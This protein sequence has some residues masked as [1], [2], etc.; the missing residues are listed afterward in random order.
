MAETKS[1][2]QLRTQSN[3][4]VLPSVRSYRIWT[5]GRLR[6]AERQADSGLIRDAVDICDW[7]LGDDRVRGALDARLDA[8]F[9]LTPTFETGTGRKKR[10]ALKAL[11]ADEDFWAIFPEE[12]ARQIQYWAILLG[13]GPGIARWNPDEDHGD[14]DLPVVKFYHPQPLKYDWN[15]RTWMRSLATSGHRLAG[16]RDEPVVFGDGVWVGHMPRGSYRPWS[17]GLWR[18]IAPWVLLKAYARSDW[19]SLGEAASRTVFELDKELDD[20]RER[21]KDLADSIRDMGNGGV[22]VLP[23]GYKHQLV[24]ASAATKELYK[25]QIDMANL[26][27]T[28]TIRGGNLTTQV[29]GQGSLAA[30]KQQAETNDLGKLRSDATGWSTT[31]HDQVLVHWA[32]S[33]YGDPRLAPWPVYPVK[34]KD[35]KQAEATVL[36]DAMDGAEKAENMGFELDRK[37]FIE[38]F[39]FEFLKPGDPDARPKPPE[40]TPDPPDEGDDGG[41]ND[42]SGGAQARVRVRRDGQ[43]DAQTYTDKVE[44]SGRAVGAKELAST[45]AAMVAEVANAGDYDEARAAIIERYGALAAPAELA[46]ATEAAINLSQLAG[47][48]GVR[49]DVPELDDDES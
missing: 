33:N 23:P 36:G 5:P 22:I 42:D 26:A 44:R 37:A 1:A 13:L 46:T 30:T 24:E 9:G 7:L 10:A 48:L 2:Q 41:D 20:T 27:I 12:E 19:A 21:R 11:E 15:E 17:L 34:P 47:H 29:S 4:I 16:G 25:S 8:F 38:H 14:R 39:E 18:A 43:K 3:K 6:T 35:D 45:V 28:I 31:S 32:G 49:E 40:P